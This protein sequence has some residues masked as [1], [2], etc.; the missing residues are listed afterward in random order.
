MA[1]SIA[2]ASR[3]ALLREFDM[4]EACGEGFPEPT[5]YVRQMLPVTLA[6]GSAQ[7]GVDLHLQLAGREA[8]AHRVGR[9]L[10]RSSSR[11]HSGARAARAR[12]PSL[13]HAA[14]DDSGLALQAPR[15]DEWRTSARFFG[16]DFCCM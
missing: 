7:R 11:R 2:C 8:D 9:F 16:L 15:N 5:Q 1:S 10:A 3:D 12:N 13:P 14:D 4:Y 6:D